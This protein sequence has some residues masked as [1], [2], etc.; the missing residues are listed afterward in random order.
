M[1]FINGRSTAKRIRKSLIETTNEKRIRLSNLATQKRLLRL[2]EMTKKI[3]YLACR[4]NSAFD[5]N[6][7]IEHYC[8]KMDVLCNYCGSRNFLAEKNSQGK[9][10]QCCHLGKVSLPSQN[11]VPELLQNYLKTDSMFLDNIR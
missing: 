7:I 4:F 5:E 8:G 2:T 10:L 3:N 9:F 1:S 6:E 11:D